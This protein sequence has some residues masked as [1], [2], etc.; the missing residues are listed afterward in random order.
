MQDLHDQ[1]G[2][3]LW[4]KEEVAFIPLMSVICPLSIQDFHPFFELWAEYYG[5]EYDSL[6]FILPFS[7]DDFGSRSIV[8]KNEVRFLFLI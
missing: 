7:V 3:L 2:E 5:I 6:H 4:S 1:H 8:S